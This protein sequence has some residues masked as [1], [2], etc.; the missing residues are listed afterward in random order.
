MTEEQINTAKAA[1]REYAGDLA[2][3]P[4]DE[5]GPDFLMEGSIPFFNSNHMRDAFAAG[6]KWQMEQSTKSEKQ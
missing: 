3:K 6:A 1:G 2:D 4:E 5:G